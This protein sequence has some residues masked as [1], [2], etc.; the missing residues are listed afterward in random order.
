MKENKLSVLC[1]SEEA[2][3]RRG[4]DMRQCASKD[5]TLGPKER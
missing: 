5:A 2:E 3:P 1:A 4:M